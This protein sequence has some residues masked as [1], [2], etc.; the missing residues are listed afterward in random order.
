MNRKR[1]LNSRGTRHAK[2]DAIRHFETR[3]LARILHRAHDLA[4]E[5]FVDEFGVQRRVERRKE[6]RIRLARV[7]FGRVRFDQD[8]VALKRN[9]LSLDLDFECLAG[10][11]RAGNRGA[12]SVQQRLPDYIQVSKAIKRTD[13]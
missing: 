2:R 11:R 7:A 13:R 1:V 8:V 12:V 4:R 9:R 6:A 3:L 10:S 5:A